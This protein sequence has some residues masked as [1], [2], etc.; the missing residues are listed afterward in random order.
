MASLEA[1]TTGL[2][3]LQESFPT[4]EITGKTGEVWKL[5]FADVDDAAFLSACTALA[6]EHGRTFFP[7]PGE[8]MALACPAPVID[9]ADILTQI[10]DLGE[11]GPTGWRYPSIAAIRAALGDQVGTAYIDAGGARV[12]ADNE[13]TRDIAR[14]EFEKALAASAKRPALTLIGAQEPKRIAAGK[15]STGFRRLGE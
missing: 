7:T 11:Y 5:L 6:V 15:R 2:S 4:R 3:L 14:R 12:F 9:S 10:H 13:T 1:V 8:I